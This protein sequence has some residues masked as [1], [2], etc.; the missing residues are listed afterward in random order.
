MWRYDSANSFSDIEY[1]Q[2]FL[3]Q[4]LVIILKKLC[5]TDFAGVI[6]QGW[7]K[8]PVHFHTIAYANFKNF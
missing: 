4:I 3:V 1:L 5:N 2:H 8:V 6:S 7:I